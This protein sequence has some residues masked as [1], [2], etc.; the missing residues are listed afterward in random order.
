LS[1]SYRLPS[2]G[3]DAGRQRPINARTRTSA[4]PYLRRT[5]Q[6]DDDE[7]LRL[8]ILAV[9]ARAELHRF[10]ERVLALQ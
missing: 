4:D 8:M 2:A 3:G 5:A 1:A 10:G 9:L 6:D 7:L